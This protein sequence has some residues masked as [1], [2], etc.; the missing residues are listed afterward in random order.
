[1]SDVRCL[2]SNI[3]HPTSTMLKTAL[4]SV[5]DKT[6]LV[7][8]ARKLHA[9]G[10]A[11]I[12]TGGTRA[13]LT[14]ADLPTVGIDTV[15]GFPEM[16]DGRVKTL[17]PNVHGGLLAVR[18]NPAHAAA[19][20]QHGITPID[21]VCVNLYP[22]E[23]T[24]ANDGVTTEQAIEQI[25]IGGPSMIRSAAK[26]HRYVTVVTAPA[27][28]DAVSNELDAPENRGNTTLALR[29]KL[30]AAAFKRTSEYDTAIAVWLAQRFA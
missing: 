9:R 17:H 3:T 28:Y 25:D 21:L 10:V 11:L 1:M 18:D 5:S 15:T 13:A 30:A 23:A 4:L 26:N 20:Q 27:Q 8:F 16:M 22:F 29:R 7:P 19:L 24:V 2:A 6:D 12:S 14:E